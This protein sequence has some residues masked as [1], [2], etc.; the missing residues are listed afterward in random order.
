[1]VKDDNAL[2]KKMIVCRYVPTTPWT[3]C[4]SSNDGMKGSSI[5]WRDIT[6]MGAE[7]VHRKLSFN[8]VAKKRIGRGTPYSFG[9]INGLVMT[10]SNTC[11]PPYIIF[12]RASMQL[13]QTW[14]PGVMMHGIRIGIG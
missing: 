7:L 6:S 11:F 8:E 10:Q 2:W 13:W 1:M 14:G 4:E 12:A 3:N 9:Q 5:W